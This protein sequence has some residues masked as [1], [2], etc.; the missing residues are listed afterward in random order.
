MFPDM[1]CPQGE[2]AADLCD[3]RMRSDFDPL[4]DSKDFDFLR[5]AIWRAQEEGKTHPK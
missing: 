3:V 2:E 5:C 4:S 1:P